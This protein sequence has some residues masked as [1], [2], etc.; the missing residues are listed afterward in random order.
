[1]EAKFDLS[2]IETKSLLLATIFSFIWGFK[3]QLDP[4]LPI[5]LWKFYNYSVDVAGVASSFLSWV[6][7]IQITILFAI[8]FYICDRNFIDKI[9]STI[10]SIV[11]GNV[12]GFWIGYLAS[13]GYVLYSMHTVYV[14]PFASI[15]VSLG[16]EVISLLLYEIVAIASAFL[17]RE[18]D[19]KLEQAGFNVEDTK[20]PGTAFVAFILY[21]VFGIISLILAFLFAAFGHLMSELLAKLKIFVVSALFVNGA[22]LLAVAYGLYTGKRWG[23][24]FAFISSTIGVITS[25]NG[26]VTFVIR[27]SSAELWVLIASLV[28]LTLNLIALTCLLPSATREYFRFLNVETGQSR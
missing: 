28:T 13:A 6:W 7:Y 8:F 11:I 14:E 17:I 3:R 9:G 16:L 24:L 23:W 12:I 27:G 1:M 22:A 5:I 20:R 18:W 26:M 4:L 2:L 21:A 10:I 19:Q 25:I 15:N